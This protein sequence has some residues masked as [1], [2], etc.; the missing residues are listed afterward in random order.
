MFW[1][2]IILGAIL[3]LIVGTVAGVLMR[4]ACTRVE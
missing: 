3:G 4:P 2:G 1:H